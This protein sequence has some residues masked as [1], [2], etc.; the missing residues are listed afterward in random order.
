[1]SSDPAT[2]STTTSMAPPAVRIASNVLRRISEPNPPCRRTSIRF[3]S[4]RGGGWSPGP[5][6]LPVDLPPPAP[7]RA[8][9]PEGGRVV[10]AGVLEERAVPGAPAVPPRPRRS[11]PAASDLDR[12]DGEPVAPLS[13]RVGPQ[14]QLPLRPGQQRAS[15]RELLDD[16]L[17]HHAPGAVFLDVVHLEDRALHERVL[18]L[19]ARGGPEHDQLV[20]EGVVDGKDLRVPFHHQPDPSQPPR[21]QQP[22]AL[23]RREPL[24]LIVDP[25]RHQPPPGRPGA[26]TPPSLPKHDPPA[27]RQQRGGRGRAD[28]APLPETVGEQ[29]TVPAVPGP[30]S[31]A[32]PTIRGPSCPGAG[33]SGPPAS[34][35]PSLAWPLAERFRP[36]RPAPKVGHGPPFSGT[37]VR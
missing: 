22:V 14:L 20:E 26:T 1:M 34:R 24:H 36:R 31:T 28:G 13:G 32:R 35:R 25:I 2:S 7:P 18:E 9:G 4:G 5:K 21:G 27:R 12:V 33:A 8:H 6:V 15:G 30:S 29:G 3:E 19:G 10:A 23:G 37:L 17:H 16:A 11:E